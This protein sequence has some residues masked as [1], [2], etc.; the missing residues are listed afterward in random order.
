MKTSLLLNF[1]V[2]KENKKITVEREFAAPVSQ[3]WAAWTESKLLDQWWAPKPWKARTKSQDFKV[4]GTWLY[5]MVGPDGTEHFARLDYKTI[6]PQKS[7]EG[8]DAFADET[9]NINDE[10]PRMNWKV[11][12]KPSPE[13]TK[14]EVEIS[15]SSKAD[16]EKIIETGF[17]EGFTAA[18]DNLDELLA[19]KK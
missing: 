5:S 4:G 19:A 3:V 6:V 10:F 7:F 12:F 17:Q 14:V 8:L 11:S 13:G 15:Y 1:S 16:M 9:G 2:D 18:H